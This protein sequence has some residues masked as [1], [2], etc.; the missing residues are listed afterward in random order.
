[1]IITL[2]YIFDKIFLDLIVQ[3]FKLKYGN[4]KFFANF[5]NVRED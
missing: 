5:E 1:M 4:P 2:K 3:N